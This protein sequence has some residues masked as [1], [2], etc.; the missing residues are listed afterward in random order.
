MTRSPRPP[1]PI[2]GA[3]LIII[4]MMNSFD[5]EGGHALA[6]QAE[7]ASKN[8]VRL[9]DYF[10][11]A[12][13][14]VMYVNDNFMIGGRLPGNRSRL[15]AGR[16]HRVQQRRSTGAGAWPVPRRN[17][18]N[19]ATALRRKPHQRVWC[20]SFLIESGLTGIRSRHLLRR[21]Q[22]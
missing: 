2:H 5:F 11:G 14:P 15:H 16:S 1:N 21:L 3:A 12:D 20:R 10:D 19:I 8:I 6:V 17:I 13:L 22:A 7:S 9:R 4:D 18:R